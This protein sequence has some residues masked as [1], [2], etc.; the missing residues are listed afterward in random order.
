MN[1]AVVFLIVFALRAVESER[2]SGA[3]RR[4]FGE[5][6]VADGD[7]LKVEDPG[8]LW[9]KSGSERS[10]NGHRSIHTNSNFNS[11]EDQELS[12]KDFLETYAKT[13]IRRPTYSED[14][15][16]QS[17]DKLIQEDDASGMSK[18]KPKSSWALMNAQKHKHPYEDR[19]GWVSLDPIPWSVSKISKWQSK[20]K[21]STEGPW[22]EHIQIS[23]QR[24]YL[25]EDDD[26]DFNRPVSITPPNAYMYHRPTESSDRYDSFYDHGSRPRPTPA[27][28]I[29]PRPTAFYGHKVQVEAH[30][31]SNSH[32]STGRPYSYHNQKNCN[33]PNHPFHDDII[34]DGMPSNFPQANPYDFLRRQGTELEMQSENHSPKGEG[35]WVLLST[36]KGYKPPRNQRQRSLTLGSTSEP[37]Q[38]LRASRGVRL[39]VLPPLKGSS[40][41]M[42]TSHGGLLQVESTFESV[43]EAK[44]NFDHKQNGLKI[45]AKRKRRKPLKKNANKG[46]ESSS[47]NVGIVP[48]YAD[49]GAVMAAV[50]AGM[51]PATMAMMVPMAMAG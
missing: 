30:Y 40:V 10:E 17:L 38:I 14:A 21:P 24:P 34:T 41:N 7:S 26:A 22:D 20:Y 42:T 19:K 18:D 29:Y 46:V 8:S 44:Q 37:T 31:P 35:E 13:H 11:H 36:T 2:S 47:Q 50:G 3:L 49:P 9:D 39:T 32:S 5:A 15:S 1:C 16:S 28:T 12:L 4:S 25:Q 45:K 23:S 51:I 33:R 27:P 43:E 48:Q 6:T